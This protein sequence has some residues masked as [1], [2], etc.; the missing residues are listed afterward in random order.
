MRKSRFTESQI[1]AML[2]SYGPSF[3]DMYRRAAAYVDQIL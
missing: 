2:M 3:P 1:V